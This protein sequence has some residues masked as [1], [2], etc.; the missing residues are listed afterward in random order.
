MIVIG[1]IDAGQKGAIAWFENGRANV[2][3]FS[4]ET[5]LDVCS[6]IPMEFCVLEQVHAMPNQGVTSMFN[7]GKNYGWIRGVLDANNIPI[8]DVT[9]Q[10]WKS[11]FG[12]IGKEKKDSIELC[13]KLYPDVS[14]LR[15]PKCKT[16]HDGMAEALLIAEY[17]RRNY[18]N[19][20]SKGKN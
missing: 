3:P 13:K 14:L 5:F 15:T 7:F 11:F 9:P 12:L 2:F 20:S 18:A 16:N 4:E 6:R 8:I 19:F 1:G 17:G 10:K